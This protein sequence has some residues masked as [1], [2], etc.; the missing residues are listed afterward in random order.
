MEEGDDGFTLRTTSEA[1]AELESVGLVVRR[2]VRR[3]VTCKG[4]LRSLKLGSAML[5]ER[6]AFGVIPVSGACF[7]G[8]L[9]QEQLA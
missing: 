1:V 8:V 9:H 7:W 5:P 6:F 4:M 3:E 2:K